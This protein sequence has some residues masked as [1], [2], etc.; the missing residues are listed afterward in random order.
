[1]CYSRVGVVCGGGFVRPCQNTYGFPNVKMTP[2]IYFYLA[3][4]NNKLMH[5]GVVQV[6]MSLTCTSLLWQSV[7]QQFTF[8]IGHTHSS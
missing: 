2:M 7:T 3:T 8:R 5:K 6:I 4:E 1:M